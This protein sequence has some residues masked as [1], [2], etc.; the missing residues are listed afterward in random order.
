MRIEL[1]MKP[2]VLVNLIQGWGFGDVPPHVAQNAARCKMRLSSNLF[3]INFSSGKAWPNLPKF[4]R[5][6]KKFGLDM[7]LSN[8]LTGIFSLF[9]R[10]GRA[11]LLMFEKI[12]GNE[13]IASIKTLCD[14]ERYG[15]A[16]VSPSTQRTLLSEQL[17]SPEPGADSPSGTMKDDDAGLLRELR[18]KQIRR[19]DQREGNEVCFEDG[20]QANS[21]SGSKGSGL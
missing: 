17:L 13:L 8:T 20:G 15:G 10:Y 14:R 9:S 16:D 18:D 4:R 1:R 21:P 11:A 7:M 2:A 5:T 19:R 3:L 6:G 12:E